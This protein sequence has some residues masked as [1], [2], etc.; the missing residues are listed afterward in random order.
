MEEEEEGE[1]KTW[2]FRQLLSCWKSHRKVRETGS[3][4]AI[5]GLLAS[6]KWIYPIIRL[7]PTTLLKLGEEKIYDEV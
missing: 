5:Q 2:K 6:T 4:M 3:E 1:D 7:S